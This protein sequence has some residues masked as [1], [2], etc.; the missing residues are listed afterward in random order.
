M[1]TTNSP[2]AAPP[3]AG[4]D[5][6]TT[7]HPEPGR[8]AVTDAGWF[9][10]RPDRRYRARPGSL[11]RRVRGA[12][13][14]VADRAHTV[15]DEQIIEAAWWRAAWPQLPENAREKLIRVARRLAR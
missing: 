13:L 15:D 12:H 1:N 5:P 2:A 9:E 4:A 11:I 7:H 3:A 8:A 10:E 6:H 14:R